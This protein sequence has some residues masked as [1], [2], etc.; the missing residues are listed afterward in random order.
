VPLR[1]HEVKGR[2]DS[3]EKKAA[4]DAAFVAVEQ[5]ELFDVI[6]AANFLNINALLDLTCRTVAEMLKNKTPG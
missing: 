5:D 1:Y 3:D 6:V 2:G 4:F